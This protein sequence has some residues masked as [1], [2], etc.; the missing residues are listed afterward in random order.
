MKRLTRLIGW[1]QTEHE[2]VAALLSAYI[3]ERVDTGE[4]RLVE[5]HLQACAACRTDLATLRATVQAVQAMPA[6]RLP[7]SFTL[8]RSMARQPRPNWTFPIFRT[9]TVV[10]AAL[11][12]MVLAGDMAGL[13]RWMPAAAPVREFQTELTAPA[14]EALPEMP[15]VASTEAKSAAPVET[16]PAGAI[17]AAS[18]PTESPLG[19]GTGMGGGV[20]T[21]LGVGGGDLSSGSP[22]PP[23]AA[24]PS[25]A[26]WDA[27]SP[28]PAPLPELAPSEPSPPALA[29]QPES[30][31]ATRALAY[32]APVESRGW[33]APFAFLRAVEIG[34]AGLALLLGGLA[35]VT[36]GRIRLLRNIE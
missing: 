1:G 18:V 24:T 35:L 11:F 17:A 10:A 28:P 21:E 23:E 5:K 19:L 30:L 14:A 20:G 25:I 4:R 15:G 32:A 33:Q 6:P 7:R 27:S 13:S 36:S 16:M 22:P 8:P 12:V 2:R 34:L 9:A 3:D 31:P 29:A 26:M